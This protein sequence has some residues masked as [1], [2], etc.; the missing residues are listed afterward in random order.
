MVVLVSR[1]E[2]SAALGGRRDEASGAVRG[3]GFGS[4]Q[5]S[6]G[7][8]PHGR[9]SGVGQ[10]EI[11]IPAELGAALSHAAGPPRSWAAGAGATKPVVP[12]MRFLLCGPGGQKYKRGRLGGPVG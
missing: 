10:G 11:E 8:F 5:G 3:P 1:D 12:G 9:A 2:S 7:R 6:L 4:H